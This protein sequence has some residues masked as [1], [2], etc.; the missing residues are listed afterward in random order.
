MTI[1]NVEKSDEKMFTLTR[2]N[3]TNRSL[4]RKTIED[5]LGLEF[6][7]EDKAN[8]VP[9]FEI[10]R[11]RIH[12]LTI[13]MKT[14]KYQLENIFVSDGISYFEVNYLYSCRRF[15][16]NSTIIIQSKINKTIDP[17]SVSEIYPN[18]QIIEKNISKRL[19]INFKEFSRKSEEQKEYLCKPYS[20]Q[21]PSAKDNPLK[22]GIFHPIHQ[23]NY[24]VE[25]FT[26]NNR[27]QGVELRDG[28]LYK[29]IQPRL[30]ELDP[31]L[32][33]NTMFETLSEYSNVAI[34][35]AFVD[36]IESV[37]EKKIPNKVRY[38][39]TLLAELERIS[40]HLIWMV[41]LA[42]LLGNKLK[43]K[44]IY[45]RYQKF[46]YYLKTIFH[47]PEL[48]NT[49]HIGTSIDLTMKEARDFWRF[50]KKWQKRF[51]TL[52]MDWYMIR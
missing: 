10:N 9:I 39:R 24:Y 11:S 2:Q 36:N 26:E 37:L 25:L 52:L 18:A 7:K 1:T 46:E 35:L 51:L 17:P 49:I 13:F 19:G 27:I 16:S 3:L 28:W 41:N 34:N 42:D 44:K 47:H 45:R 31:L 29:G 30:E 5:Y 50:T 21:P 20:I 15:L 33:Y 32:Q 40:H 38:I 6:I 4:F 14:A 43:A 8:K 23:D 48:F 22:Y 12:D